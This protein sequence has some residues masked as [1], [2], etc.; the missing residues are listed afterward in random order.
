MSRGL[1]SK[2]CRKTHDQLLVLA[3]L[4]AIEPPDFIRTAIAG[5]F[6]QL[7][8][9]EFYRYLRQSL[10]FPRF[11]EESASPSKLRRWYTFE[12]KDPLARFK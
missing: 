1:T 11:A 8:A 2:R 9:E 3:K 5:G 10:G 6:T 12:P 7:E 4:D